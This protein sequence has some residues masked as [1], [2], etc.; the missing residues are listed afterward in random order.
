MENSET[1]YKAALQKLESEYA[2]FHKIGAGAYN[3]GL[4]TTTTLAERLG[5][6]HHKFRTVHVAGT[7]GKGSVAH[8]LAAVLQSAGYRTGLYTSPHLLDFRERIR[9]DGEKVSKD[10]VAS[11]VPRLDAV[12]GEF[13]PSYFE[14]ATLMAFEYFAECEVD[15]AVIEVGLG[16]RLDST[17]IITP[18]LSIITNISHDHNAILGNTLEEIAAEKAGIIKS[19]VPVVIGEAE[20]DVRKVF[21][22][23]ACSEHAPIIFAAENKLYQSV[24]LSAGKLVYKGTPWGDFKGE[25][26]ADCQRINTNTILNALEVLKLTF[27]ID[28][29][30]VNQGFGNVASIAG[31]MGRWTT[32]QSAPVRIICDTGHNPGG[33]KLMAPQ[34]KDLA[35]NGL[36]MVLGFVNDKD[37]DT[38]MEYMPREGKYYFTA[39]SSDRARAAVDTAAHAAAHGIEGKAYPAVADAITA[40]KATAKPGETIFI[41]GSNFVVADALFCFSCSPV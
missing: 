18:L 9:V 34:L 40:A 23:K 6:P 39:P 19:G 32:L 8:T 38:I 31:L 29:K 37:I 5:N 7:N 10:F 27:D 35:Q 12:K 13:L 25:L 11:F 30:A 21:E 36:H 1:Q 28:A 26:T 24:D 14:A 33:W 2:A 20:G 41:G 3:P 17:N 16:G 4:E 22:E 15:V